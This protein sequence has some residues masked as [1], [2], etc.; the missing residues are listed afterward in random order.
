M[1]QEY[2]LM[3]ALVFVLGFVVARMMSGR[4]VEGD[5]DQS[6]CPKLP[7]PKKSKF[8]NKMECEDFLNKLKDCDLTKE[9]L[10]NSLIITIFVIIF[11]NLYNFRN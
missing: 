10:P 1:K 8:G 7:L 6:D 5:R 2:L 3:Y 9:D 4:L 11:L